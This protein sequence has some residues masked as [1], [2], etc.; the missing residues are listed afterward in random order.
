[1]DWRI[2]RSCPFKISPAI[3]IFFLFSRWT[4]GSPGLALSRSLLLSRYF[5]S[6]LDGLEDLPVLP[7]QDLSCYQGNSILWKPFTGYSSPILISSRYFFSFL[8]G[9]EDLPVLPS[10]D[11][12]CYQGNSILW[13]PFT[14]YSS[15]ILISS[16]NFF[17]FF[18]GLEDLPVLPSQDLSYYQ[19]NSILWKPFTGYSSPILMSFRNFLFSRWTGGSP[20]LALSRSLLLSRYPL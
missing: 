7:S 3:K 20:G 8:D 17:S 15:P 5:F 11:L 9:L 19:G 6:F 4:G 10:Q 14:G 13:K 2:S 18:D 12:S 1:M 16:R